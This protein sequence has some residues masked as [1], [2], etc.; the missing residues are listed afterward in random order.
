MGFWNWIVGEVTSID[1]L[2]PVVADGEVVIAALEKVIADIKAGNIATTVDD[3]KQ[4]ALDVAA[5]ATEVET[6][7]AALPSAPANVTTSISN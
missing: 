2:K 7:I 1:E 5:F 4:I 3:V 6:V